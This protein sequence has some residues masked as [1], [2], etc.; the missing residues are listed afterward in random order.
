MRVTLYKSTDGQ[1]HETYEAFA[2][3][4]QA[5]KVE[6]MMSAVE[7]K[8]DTTAFDKDEYGNDVLH[9]ASLGEFVANNADV[10]REVLNAAVIVKRGRK[11]ASEGTGI[12]QP[13]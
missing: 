3:R 9:M 2:A 7:S 5:L 8:L 6:A 12:G 4:E 10:L 13:A 1:L 11:P